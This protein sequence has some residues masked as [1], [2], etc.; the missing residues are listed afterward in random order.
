MSSASLGKCIPSIDDDSEGYV[1]PPTQE[2]NSSTHSLEE[3]E[4]GPG[5]EA[6]YIQETIQ[7]ALPRRVPST[8]IFS[9][10]IY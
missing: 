10:L 1:H 7:D 5:P 9:F 8:G 6:F 3:S 4:P 2:R